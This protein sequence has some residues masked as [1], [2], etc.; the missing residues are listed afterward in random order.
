MDAQTEGQM[1]GEIDK[2]KK[3]LPS[4]VQ[5]LA[6]QR[7][8]QSFKMTGFLG[9]TYSCRKSSLDMLQDIRFI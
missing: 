1:D 6:F 4:V 2:S 5:L 3:G 7:L 8:W 9:M